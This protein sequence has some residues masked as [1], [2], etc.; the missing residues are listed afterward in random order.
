MRIVFI[1]TILHYP[2]GGADKL[3][4]EAA[5]A[6]VADRHD[7]L[8]A[9]S[10]LTASHPLIKDLQASG[11]VV[12]ERTEHTSDKGRLSR[13]RRWLLRRVSSPG[14]LLARLDRF[15]PDFVFVNQGGT[16]DFLLEDGLT[17]WL[18]A[19]QTPF[20]LI[21]QSN[22]ESDTLDSV[23]RV[24]AATITGRA[25][26]LVFVSHHNRLLA[27]QQ[28]G[29]TLPNAIVVHNPVQ[30][31]FPTPLAW[32]VDS[33]EARFAV[34][35]RLE[36]RDKGLDILIQSLAGTLGREA[37]WSLDIYGRG[38]DEATLQSLAGQC[39]V[40]NCVHFKGFSTDLRAVWSEHHLLMLPSHREG[41]ALAMLEAMRCGRPILAT[42]VGGVSDWIK[43]GTNGFVA[44]ECSVSALS[45]AIHE[46]WS[47][48]GT[49]PRMGAASHQISLLL[50]PAPGRTLLSLT[51]S[52]D[53][54]GPN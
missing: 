12:H 4:T 51:T 5:V 45:E 37:G 41:C 11:A 7:V 39:G 49:W 19:N 38:P 17:G 26:H 29:R 23:A 14:S 47:Q 13:W 3:W 15:Q 20:A 36:S 31:L 48:R 8:I 34:L 9:I 40:G 21:C 6:A 54:N 10:P 53:R 25:R 16:Y 42:P 24:T 50:D 35:A 18:Q 1:S 33:T 43:P 28:I 32:P 27:E 30:L 52:S 22:S 2:F 46:T 44:R